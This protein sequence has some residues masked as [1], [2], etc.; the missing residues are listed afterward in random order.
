MKNKVHTPTFFSGSKCRYKYTLFWR[1]KSI[2][3][4]RPGK[5]MS[6][7]RFYLAIPGPHWSRISAFCRFT[8]IG[9]VEGFFCFTLVA[10]IPHWL[11]RPLV[12]PRIF[13]LR[14]ALIVQIKMHHSTYTPVLL[15]HNGE[16]GHTHFILNISGF[17]RALRYQTND[18]YRS[19]FRA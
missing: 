4:P 1:W 2:E 15:Y 18:A 14:P 19:H 8:A 10:P 16:W 9:A 6:P 11:T 17:C 12:K 7:V 13:S 3:Y 5:N